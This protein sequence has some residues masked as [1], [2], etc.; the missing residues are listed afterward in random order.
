MQTHL[1]LRQGLERYY[2][3]NS[4]LKRYQD[5]R[6]GWLY[7]PWVD[8]FKHDIL[9]VVTGYGTGLD[10]ELTLIGF[11]L[12]AVSWKRPWY[13]YLQSFGTFLELLLQSCQGKAWGD[14]YYAPWA[15][16]QC[17]FKGVCQGFTVK[18]KIN[19]YLEPNEVLDRSLSDLRDEYGIVNAGSWD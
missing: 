17:Y 10:H 15:V 18:K 19:A 1:T 11:L 12:T 13:F 3:A 2:G 9:H 4:S 8:L 14:T 6:V 7:I 16:C 5:L